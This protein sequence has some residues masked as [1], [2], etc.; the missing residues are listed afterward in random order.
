MSIRRRPRTTRRRPHSYPEI[1]PPLVARSRLLNP[2]A[3]LTVSVAVWFTLFLATGVR[4]TFGSSEVGYWVLGA[5]VAVMA[6]AMAL[7]AVVGRTGV[8]RQIR[9]QQIRYSPASV[10]RAL[11][12]LSILALLSVWIRAVLGGRWFPS[13]SAL[14]I[15][16][17]RTAAMLADDGAV[18][19]DAIGTPMSTLGLAAAIMWIAYGPRRVNLMVSILVCLGLLQYVA[20]GLAGG[21]RTHIAFLV[22]ALAAARSFDSKP[23]T[24]KSALRGLGAAGLSLLAL[25]IWILQGRL[26][27]S[28]VSS[29]Q[30]ILLMEQ[31]HFVKF[32][33]WWIAASSRHPELQAAIYAL[34]SLVHYFLHGVFEFANLYDWRSVASPTLTYGAMTFG[35]TVRGGFMAFGLDVPIAAEVK[36]R[37]GIYTT[38]WG[39]LL[40][41]YGVLGTLIASLVLG[42]MIGV[43]YRRARRNASLGWAVVYAPI[44][45]IVFAAPFFNAISGAYG[46]YCVI[47]CILAAALL[48]REV[49]SS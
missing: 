21:S 12:I 49:G 34:A 18:S 45:A 13:A 47:A 16:V 23:V 15:A 44:V 5:S 9:A 26:A 35:S 17:S 25:S 1:M 20:F 30:G 2:V 3:A 27:Q 31:W 7:G 28:S 14:D 29:D 4:Y 38:L 8:S 10:S 42:V 39:D 37:V 11:S 32:P 33:D 41:D 6:I 36:P 22:A 19:L 40:A 48:R 24:I 46:L 43:C